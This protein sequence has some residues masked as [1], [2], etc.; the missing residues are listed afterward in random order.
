MFLFVYA[1]VHLCVCGC[2]WRNQVGASS[3]SHKLAFSSRSLSE[4]SVKAAGGHQLPTANSLIRNMFQSLPV[5]LSLS[6][7]AWCDLRA[8]SVFVCVVRVGRAGVEW[9]WKRW[10]LS[11]LQKYFHFPLPHSETDSGHMWSDSQPSFSFFFQSLSNTATKTPSGSVQRKP[12]CKHYITCCVVTLT[13]L[14]DWLSDGLVGGWVSWLILCVIDS[15]R[16]IMLFS[17]NMT[18]RIGCTQ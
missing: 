13:L 12:H 10:S 8:L 14:L 16:E 4:Q 5:S 11:D 3:C 15:I 1:W 17:A 7:L 9:W 2:W 6:N 18:N